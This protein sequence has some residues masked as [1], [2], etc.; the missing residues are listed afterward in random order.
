MI[1]FLLLT[2]VIKKIFLRT[3][4]KE[5]LML[6]LFNT[7]EFATASR[8]KPLSLTRLCKHFNGFWPYL[9]ACLVPKTVAGCLY[10]WK[11]CS[12]LVRGLPLFL[13]FS[14]SL[15]TSRWGPLW[16]IFFHLARTFR[17]KYWFS[18][19]NNACSLYSSSR[20]LSLS[21]GNKSTLGMRLRKYPSA[22]IFW[23]YA[24]ISFL[25]AYGMLLSKLAW[26]R[27]S[28][29][30]RWP[31]LMKALGQTFLRVIFSTRLGGNLSVRLLSSFS[32]SSTLPLSAPFSQSSGSTSP[33]EPTSPLGPW[34]R[35]LIMSSTDIV[36][37]NLRWLSEIA[38]LWN[39]RE[40]AARSWL[41]YG[42]SPSRFC[43]GAFYGRNGDGAPG[44]TR[45]RLVADSL[46]MWPVDSLSP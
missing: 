45:R 3:T 36:P 35:I 21:S 18:S 44:A 12:R 37:R 14:W 39:Q 32:S 23:I 31:P 19:P 27:L 4:S 5:S 17:L 22:L 26:T 29:P 20:C 34:L 11:A 9:A 6:S 28:L 8:L 1:L 24:A 2:L 10:G 46:S 42:P 16:G 41:T 25:T 13:I 30:S 7:Q 15:P 43:L 40:R 38:C 33:A